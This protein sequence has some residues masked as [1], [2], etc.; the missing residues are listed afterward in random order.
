[1]R[2]L[3]PSATLADHQRNQLAREGL[4]L[5]RSTVSTLAAYLEEFP[6]TAAVEPAAFERILA[7]L[8]AA[9]CPVDYEPV[10]HTPGFLR[11][12]GSTLESLSLAR[13]E[14]GQLDGALA[15]VYSRALR[16]LEAKQ[17]ALRG[18]RLRQAAAL[19][20]AGEIRLPTLLLDGF[21]SF[22]AAEL[23]F[24]EALASR[25]SVTVT[26][27]DDSVG[28]AHRRPQITAWNAADQ[29]QEILVIA[30]RILE[31]AQLGV[32]LRRIGV[33][34]RNPAQYAPLLDSVF[35]RLGVPSRSYLG[36]PLM[37]HPVAGFYRDFL[38]AVDAEWDYG[39]LLQAMRWGHTG[40]GGDPSGDELERQLR[41]AMPGSGID[42]FLPL[43]PILTDFAD[44]PWRSFSPIEAAQELRKIR[45]LFTSPV[46][47]PDDLESAW[48]W[49]QRASAVEGIE[50]AF[51]KTAAELAPD[52]ALR[53][54]DFWRE[55]QQRLRD[56]TLRERDSRRDVVHIMDLFEGRQWDLDYVFAPGLTEGD[57]PKRF[58]PDPLLS[59][60]AKRNLG[61]KTIED[62][63]AEERLLF[64]LLL[65][66]AHR[67]V[68][69]THPR[70]NDKGDPLSPSP[71]LT[72]RSTTAERCQ[73]ATPP[74][75]T[76][77]LTG[78]LSTGYRP[79]RPWSASEFE[80]YLA[81][82]WKHFARYGLKLED[83]SILPA[84]RLDI[85]CL[86]N[87]AH[88]VIR[89]WT[90][91]TS[92]NIETIA[93]RELN[94]TCLDLRIPDGYRL[95]RERI[96]LLRNLRLYANNAPLVPPGWQV[97]TEK[98]F[99]MTLDD[100]IEVRGQI[101]RY[102]LSPTGEVQAYDYK[103]SKA[104]KATEKNPIQSAL[105]T[106]FLGQEPTRQHVSRFTFVGLRDAARLVPLEGA[107]L[108]E[109]VRIARKE[110]GRVREDVQAGIVPVSPAVAANCEYCDYHDAC[111]IRAAVEVEQA[112]YETEAAD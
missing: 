29:S 43:R 55:A 52:L 105:Y 94:R 54:P 3:V 33:L 100:G 23:E 32:P 51:D 61:M 102:D 15:A 26:Q 85:L 60:N 71:F 27:V 106:I 66:R 6:V 86:G 78:Q 97:F 49:S 21:F 98:P 22:A 84:E 83:L 12:L 70:T 53:L 107:T 91:D 8:L 47:L 112:D 7:E 57:F 95:E 104:D 10:R 2:L 14:S 92:L 64:E 36:Q 63:Q 87:I 108:D 109:A 96:N 18:H 48:R 11:Q 77:P 82:P 76:A 90:L 46:E 89:A 69:L 99:T 4:V 19:V 67:Q 56:A 62:R 5:R 101:D 93:E 73:V 45:S 25:T 74:N 68:I 80:T 35:S 79:A 110:M 75:R 31:L 28:D 88:R 16:A 50:K 41:E 30:N 103:Y 20:R 39:K 38:A 58:T 59:E 44:W 9:S 17:L 65:T 34:L 1:M 40:L 42:P 13:V 37:E 24:L 111:R 72:Q 81:C